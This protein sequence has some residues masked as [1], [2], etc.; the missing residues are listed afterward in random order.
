MAGSP[1]YRL[2]A[3]RTKM[4]NDVRLKWHVECKGNMEEL[5]VGMHSN[6]LDNNMFLLN[7]SSAEWRCA[8]R[9]LTAARDVPR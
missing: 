3:Q 6:S 7:V 8:G 2:H 5:M 4:K 9:V 1:S